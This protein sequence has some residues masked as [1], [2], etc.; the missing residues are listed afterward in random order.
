MFC[1]TK[2]FLSQIKKGFSFESDT[3]T[4]VIAKLMKHI[5]DNHPD[6]KFRELVEQ[7][8]QQLV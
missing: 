2:S 5:H 1:K 3:D 8:I 6:L 4:E 7:V